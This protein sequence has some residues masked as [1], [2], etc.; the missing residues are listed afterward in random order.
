MPGFSRPVDISAHIYKPDGNGPFP[1]VI[2]LH[3]SGGLSGHHHNWARTLVSW[4]YVAAVVDS[5]LP[6]GYSQGIKERT[7]VITPYDRVSD[8]IGTIELLKTMPYVAP[9]DL[10]VIGFSHGG[11]TVMKAVQE[12]V[13]LKDYGVKGVV[14]YYPYCHPTQDVHIDVPLLI[15]IGEHDTSTPTERCRQLKANLKGR[16]AEITEMVIY[17]DTYHSFDESFSVRPVMLWS[18]GGGIK[19]HMMGYNAAASADA[20][21]RTR[22]FFEKAFR[23]G[24]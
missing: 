12:R 18:S 15:L 21:K 8:I 10:G 13:Y 16:A 5:Y 3:G 14:G 20:E 4:G 6:R 2:L 23:S 1:A 17:P 11:W 24:F 7:D 9:N 22:A 19:P